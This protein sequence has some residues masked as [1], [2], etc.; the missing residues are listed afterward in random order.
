MG[1]SRSSD[2]RARLDIR[3]GRFHRGQGGIIV[4]QGDRD[5]LAFL[6]APTSFAPSRLTTERG[7]AP[8]LRSLS[9]S[10]A[11]REDERGENGSRDARV[12]WKW[13]HGTLLEKFTWD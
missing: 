8:G 7:S 6:G 5:V 3:D 11:P 13:M 12:F 9:H 4:F 10:R 1:L 2:E